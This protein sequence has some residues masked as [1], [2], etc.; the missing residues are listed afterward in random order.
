LDGSGHLVLRAEK[1]PN[2]V[3]TSARITTRGL[4][5]FQYGRIEARMKM[6]VGAGLWPAFWMLG[7]NFATAGWPSSGSVDVVENVS[8]TSATNGVG[9]TMVR[10]TVHGPRYFRGNGLWHDFK[11][12][13]GARVDD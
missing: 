8:L 2:G 9:P 1:N 10:A 6:P 11:L 3:W 5:T 12:P 13:N 4:K 7:A